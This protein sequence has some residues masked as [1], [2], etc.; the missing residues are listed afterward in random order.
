[1]ATRSIEARKHKDRLRSLWSAFGIVVVLLIGIFCYHRWWDPA[2]AVNANSNGYQVM[3]NGSDV[4]ILLPYDQPGG[5]QTY[6]YPSLNSD[7]PVSLQCYVLLP[8]SGFWYEIYG[9]H[10]W[11]PRDAVHAIPGTSFPNPP[12]C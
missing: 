9:G 1:V 6:E 2:N 8:Q 4:Q 10:G 7:M 3:V 5:S 12:H 11:V